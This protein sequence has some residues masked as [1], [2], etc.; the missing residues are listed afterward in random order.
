VVGTPQLT[1]SAEIVRAPGLTLDPRHPL[2]R[3][4]RQAISDALVAFVDAQAGSL[5]AMGPELEPVLG[6]AHRAAAGGKRIRP[7]FCTWSYLAAGGEVADLPAVVRAAASLELLH[8]SALVHDDVMDSSDLRRGEPSV[9]RQFETLHEESGW[10]GAAD[11]FGR[12][13]AILLGDLL[14][15]WSAQLIQRSGLSAEALARALP[16][17]EEMRTEVTCGQYLDVVAQVQPLRTGPEGGADIGRALDEASRVVE[18]KSARYTV[19]RPCQAGAAMA[20][21][22]SELIEALGAYGSPLGRAFQFRD[23]V[24]GVFG[25]PGVTGKPAGDDLREGKRTVLIAHAL[26]GADAR[27]RELLASRLGDP[28]LDESGIAELQA[29]IIASGALQEVEAMIGA[30]HRQAVRALADADLTPAGRTA[31]TA[32]ADLAVHRDT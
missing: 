28:V 25:D 32:L 13:G 26:A 22:P 6:M 8:V 27:G 1:E 5:R 11:G 9:H 3:A 12:S 14:V 29:V 4:F 10:L 2:S 15:M 30:G 19:R 7:A 17:V 31:L 18:F 21:A 16:L 23:D 20:G 24:L